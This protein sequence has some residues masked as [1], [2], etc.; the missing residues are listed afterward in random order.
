MGITWTEE[1][2][3][4]LTKLWNDGYSAN[5]CA[6]RMGLG[7]TRNAIVGRVDRMRLPARKTIYTKRPQR[8]RKDVAPERPLRTPAEIKKDQAA[9][10]Q[11]KLVQ[12]LLGNPESLQ[13]PAAARPPP[14]EHVDDICRWIE[15]EPR[16]GC[17][18]PA[19]RY[20]PRSAYCLHHEAIAHPLSELAKAYAKATGF[21]LK[22]H[23]HV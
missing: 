2:C 23:A 11:E 9:A 13:P 8:R 18:C 3:D 15:G 12:F 4:L 14:K 5:E 1:R 22:E 10:L 17:R 16:K 19:K 20:G 6:T 21:P 7:L